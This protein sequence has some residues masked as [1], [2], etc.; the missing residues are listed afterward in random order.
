MRALRTASLAAVAAL[1]AL[2]GC[3]KGKMPGGHALPSSGSVPG[4]GNVPG[5]VPGASSKVDPDTCGNYAVSDAGRKLKA[6]LQAT[7][8]LDKAVTETEQVVKT[9][10]K[11]MGQ[12]LKMAPGDLEGETKDVCARVTTTLRDDL[13][14]SLKKQAALVV[15]VKPAVCTVDVDAAAQLAASCEAKAS[16][17]VSVTCSGRC[18]G[19]CSGSCS[20]KCSGGNAGGKCKGQCE[21]TCGGSCSGGCDGSADVNASAQC[22]AKAEVHASVDVHCTDPKVTVKLQKPLVLDATKAQLAVHAI[23]KGMPKILSVRARLKPLGAAVKTWVQAATELS[24]AG[25]DLAG[26]FKD[27]AMCISGQIAGAAKMIGHIQA[28][29]S[30]SVSV[31]ADASGSIG[32]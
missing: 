31:S 30:V 25:R 15:T 5:G 12:E 1:V 13:K 4:G 32:Q 29:V 23:E 7:V 11:I 2:T 9:S 18:T 8:E 27:Q 16:A 21:G 28:S 19:T 26:S 17:D 22:K 14:V 24:K 6:F 3:P 10:C 20:G